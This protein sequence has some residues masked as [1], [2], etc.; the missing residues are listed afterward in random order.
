MVFSDDFLHFLK[1][2]IFFFWIHQNYLV[3][4]RNSLSFL[5]FCNLLRN[6]SII[7]S[8]QVNI[9]ISYKKLC[10]KLQ[11][12]QI[13]G[14]IREFFFGRNTFLEYKSSL[15]W[16]MIVCMISISLG[17]ELAL[18]DV[19]IVKYLQLHGGGG[20]VLGL[21]APPPPPP[22]PHSVWSFPC[23]EFIFLIYVRFWSLSAATRT[24]M[25]TDCPEE[26]YNQTFSIKYSFQS[27]ELIWICFD[28]L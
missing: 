2:I 14:M 18:F 23:Y 12:L 6:Q 21:G 7:Q 25:Y 8:L 22:P 17:D 9:V 4:L 24:C 26:N 15:P 20:G 28:R 5:Y 11:Y 3:A 13:I 16:T 1:S 10:D 27:C 19:Y